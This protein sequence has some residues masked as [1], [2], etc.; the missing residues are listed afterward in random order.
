MYILVSMNV[1]SRN[2]PP[3]KAE[4]VNCWSIPSYPSISFDLRLYNKRSNGDCYNYFYTF[5]CMGRF[6]AFMF[7][8]FALVVA[9]IGIGFSIYDVYVVGDLYIF[10]SFP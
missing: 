6:V 3:S 2:L 9:I 10:P 4:I 7:R 8:S 1:L 5:K